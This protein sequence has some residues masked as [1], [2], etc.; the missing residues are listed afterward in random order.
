ML[1][2]LVDKADR[3][4][5]HVVGI[6]HY[7]RGVSEVVELVHVHK[8]AAIVVVVAIVVHNR[9]LGYGLRRKVYLSEVELIAC[10]GSRTSVVI[11]CI[12]HTSTPLEHGK[13]LPSVFVGRSDNSRGL[14][15]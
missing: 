13:A 3:L 5:E 6:K 1:V 15:G 10:G 2:K 12:G 4:A 7:V 11:Q 14:R 8:D 9:D